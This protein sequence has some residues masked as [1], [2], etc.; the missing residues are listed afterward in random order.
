TEKTLYRGGDTVHLTGTVRELEGIAQPRVT[1]YVA[2]MGP[3]GSTTLHQETFDLAPGEAHPFDVETA[4]YG[5]EDPLHFSA[6]VIGPN[7]G[8]LGNADWSFQKIGRAHV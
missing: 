1:L 7:Y 4:V 6:E 2:A 3:F 5:S 8:F